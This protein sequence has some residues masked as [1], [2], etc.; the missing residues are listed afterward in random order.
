MTWSNLKD[1]IATH[2][3]RRE[4]GWHGSTWRI[5]TSQFPSTNTPRNIS[6]SGAVL[7]LST[8][9]C[10][11]TNVHCWESWASGVWYTW[12]ISTSWTRTR[13]WPTSRSERVPRISGQLL[14]V[15][16]LCWIGTCGYH[17]V[18]ICTERSTAAE[19]RST[20]KLYRH[21]QLP[22]L[23]VDF[24]TRH[25]RLLATTAWWPSHRQIWS[26]G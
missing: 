23:T 24:S 26:D 20:R 17:K 12:T 7:G 6:D 5:H 2:K 1:A 15:W 3:H 19:P 10:T 13:R 25:F 14:E 9:P 4:T 18:V 8:A 11:F 21:I 22:F 16:S